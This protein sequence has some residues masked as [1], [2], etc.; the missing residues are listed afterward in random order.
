MTIYESFYTISRLILVWL[1]TINTLCN[2]LNTPQMVFLVPW[3][4]EIWPIYR[5][6]IELRNK[7]LIKFKYN[8]ISTNLNLTIKMDV[9]FEIFAARNGKKLQEM[10]SL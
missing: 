10:S 6:N 2:S 1:C 4:L 3:E 9:D 7:R 5:F 8:F